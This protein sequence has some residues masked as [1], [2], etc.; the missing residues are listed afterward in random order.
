MSVLAVSGMFQAVLPAD[1]RTPKMRPF[2]IRGV[3][4]Q[5]DLLIE[6]KFT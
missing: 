5:F 6:N 1:N 4:A 2:Y 3:C